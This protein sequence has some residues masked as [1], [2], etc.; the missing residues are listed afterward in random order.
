MID[1][2]I[3]EPKDGRHS[4]LLY[5]VDAFEIEACLDDVPAE[6]EAFAPSN[7]ETAALAAF[8]L[9]KSGYAGL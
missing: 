2:G 3:R 7:F 8:Q 6:M 4:E 9:S 5:V 1:A